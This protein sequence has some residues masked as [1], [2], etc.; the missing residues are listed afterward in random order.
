M[1]RLKMVAKKP[2]TMF[3]QK[4]CCQ[5]FKNPFPKGIFT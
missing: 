1:S 4:L 5:K 3:G 2:I